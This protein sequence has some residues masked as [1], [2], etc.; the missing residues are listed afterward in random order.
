MIVYG[1]GKTGG[2]IIGAVRCQHQS[3]GVE[4]YGKTCVTLKKLSCESRY[5]GSECQF[6]GVCWCITFFWVPFGYKMEISIFKKRVNSFIYAGFRLL[7]AIPF[8]QE[9]TEEVRQRPGTPVK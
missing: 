7:V 4:G 2:Y 8:C 5:I 9:R 3:R 1:G 6:S